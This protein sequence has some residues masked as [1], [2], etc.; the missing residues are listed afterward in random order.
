MLVHQHVDVAKLD[1]IGRM[2]GGWNMCTR[3]SVSKCLKIGKESH[4]AASRRA[5]DARI[6][7]GGGI[8][9][10][11]RRRT[12]TRGPDR[13]PIVDMRMVAIDVSDVAFS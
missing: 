9:L 8:R 3:A 6:Y 5:T 10:P 1:L 12:Y 13:R 4:P 2:K 7:R 11:S